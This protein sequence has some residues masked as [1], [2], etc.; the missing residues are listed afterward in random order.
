[1]D[2]ED[3]VRELIQKLHR[4]K[5]LVD[6]MAGVEVE[7]EVRVVIHCFERA[8]GGDDV[9]GDFRRVDFQPVT[10]ALFLKDIQNRQPAISEILITGVNVSLGVRRIELEFAPH[11]AA[12]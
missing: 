10:N 9:I 4:V 7:A 3:S 6:E 5:Q 12:G 2:M 11:A 1:M 8:F